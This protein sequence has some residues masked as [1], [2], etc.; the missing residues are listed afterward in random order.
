M[1]SRSNNLKKQTTKVS[2][3]SV[4]E[5]FAGEDMSA[6]TKFADG[7]EYMYWLHL[8][9]L[10]ALRVSFVSRNSQTAVSTCTGCIYLSCLRCVYLLCH[11]IRRRR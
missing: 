2:A 9:L 5:M 7:G 3:L 1:K 11:E 10:L 4:K 8:S 6:V